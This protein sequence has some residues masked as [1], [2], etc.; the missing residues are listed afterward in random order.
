MLKFYC[1]EASRALAELKSTPD[2]LTDA[3]SRQA[4]G[5][6]K[7]PNK[8]AEGKGHNAAALCCSS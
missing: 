6:E 3:R 8:L 2:G 5:R 7:G 4:V 1:E